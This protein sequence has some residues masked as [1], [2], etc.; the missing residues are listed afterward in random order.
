V[1]EHK[2][3]AE[4]DDDPDYEGSSELDELLSFHEYLFFVMGI[5]TF[6]TP[7]SSAQHGTRKNAR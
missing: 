1:P 5:N 4:A 2:S 7:R 6:E 3:D